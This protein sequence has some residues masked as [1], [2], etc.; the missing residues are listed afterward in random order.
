M[1]KY[2]C[3]GGVSK[4]VFW[5]AFKEYV[6]ALDLSKGYSATLS[7]LIGRVI[8]VNEQDVMYVVCYVCMVRRDGII[9]PNTNI[10]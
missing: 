6:G 8:T 1:T 2:V 4:G 5:T 10:D 3:R 9:L 7:D